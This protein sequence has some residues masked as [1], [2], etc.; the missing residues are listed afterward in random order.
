[1]TI[2]PFVLAFLGFIFSTRKWILFLNKLNPLNG[3]LIYYTILTLII[4][5]LEY[6]GLII[7]GITFKSISQTIGTMLII[8]SFFIIVCWESCY[9]NT[10]IDGNCDNVSNVYLQAEDGAVYYVW[11]QFFNNIEILR[12]LTYIVTPFVLSAIGQNL[13]TGKVVI[14]PF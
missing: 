1:M 11:S 3:L 10:V 14:S 7:A 12:I 5:T 6:F 13:I 4:V 8:F 9:I 2:L